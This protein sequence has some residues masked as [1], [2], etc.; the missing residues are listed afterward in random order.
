VRLLAVSDRVEEAWLH[1]EVRAL[2]AD[3]ILGGGDLPFDYLGWLGETLEAPVVFVP[4]NHDPDLSG[5]RVT[6]RGLVLQAGMPTVA[7]WPSGAQNA[8]GRI[9]D[10]LGL[11]IAGL[12]GSPRYS[13]GPNQ[14]SERRQ[15]R[16]AKRLIRRGR[17]AV[18]RDGHPV[19][20]LL[21]H[22]PPRGVGDAD[23]RVHQGFAA[24]LL[25]VHALRP[26]LVLH[27]HV[28][29]SVGVGSTPRIE[30]VEVVNVAGHRLVDLGVGQ[31][32]GER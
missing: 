23:D 5:Y 31:T 25:L 3:V 12:G 16:R 1:D 9:V 14:Y 30:G 19:D 6:R 32:A 17:R 29:A 28:E 24:H 27:G 10:V 22:T 4:G 18:R 11:R 20:I 26:R 7:P 15:R 21:L 8:D 2:R 13:A